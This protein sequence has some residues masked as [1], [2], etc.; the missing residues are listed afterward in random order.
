MCGFRRCQAMK[1]GQNIEIN[2]GSRTAMQRL[3]K[4]EAITLKMGSDVGPGQCNIR[5]LKV[6]Y[7][8]E[9]VN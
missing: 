9:T 5:Y 4:V 8:N 1:F 2:L 7:T 3:G 6:R